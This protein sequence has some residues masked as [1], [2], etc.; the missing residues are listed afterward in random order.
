MAHWIKN[1]LTEVM[2]VS[3]K[4]VPSEHAHKMAADLK[5]LRQYLQAQLQ[6]TIK[7]Y[8]LHSMDHRLPIPN[9]KVGDSVWLDSRNIKTKRPSKK[10]DHR[11]L[12]PFPV[13]EMVSSHAVQLG[14]PLT[15][16]RIHPVFHVSLLEPTSSSAI[17]NHVKDPPPPLELDDSD[18]YQVQQILNSKINCHCKGFGLLYLFEWNSFNNMAKSS[19]WEP[20]ENV[21]NT[22]DL[23]RV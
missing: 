18:E 3:L 9:F 16:Q 12:G 20:E 11:F 1:I 6:H 14:L 2:E 21:H 4:S 13:V 7:W 22:P 23:V 15:L 8:K 5:E 17:P 10:L 19:S